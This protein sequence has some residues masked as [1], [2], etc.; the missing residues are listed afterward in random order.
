MPNPRNDQSH[1]TGPLLSRSSLPHGQEKGT[2]VGLSARERSPDRREAQPWGTRGGGERGRICRSPS[3]HRVLRSAFALQLFA[4]LLLATPARAEDP[5]PA[6]LEEKVKVEEAALAKL[7]EK[8]TSILDELSNAEDEVMALDAAAKLAETEQQVASGKVDAALK[9]EEAAREELIH[10][11]DRLAPRLRARYKLSRR[12][13]ANLL[14][15]AKSASDLLRRKRM[16]DAVLEG[17]LE[18]LNQAREVV[19]R[20]EARRREVEEART[21]FSAKAAAAKQKR[22][23]AKQRK[24]ELSALHDVLLEEKGLREKTLAELRKQQAELTSFV[25]NLKPQAPTSAFARAKGKLRYP[26]KGFIEVAFGRVVNPKFN[27]VTFQN[28]IDLRAPAGT[29]IRS[30]FSGKVVHAGDFKGY[31]NL[32]IVDNGDGYHT[33]FAH[34]EAIERQVG[35]QVEEGD[36]IGTV[37]DT[38]SLK[39]AYLYFEI[40]EKG[41]PVDPRQWL[42]A[43]AQE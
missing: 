38:G 35:D 32:V 28:G 29:P 40:R 16:L 25:E 39:G 4:A 41:K 14:L 1:N 20:H 26:A 33:L 21:A 34:L 18:L 37:G 6:Q 11:V 5:T 19:E 30:I 9:R 2:D 17:D 12:G 42:G 22:E 31:G 13:S 10:L 3:A 15:S 36:R 8:A 7:R 23:Q 27:T 24:A 43:P